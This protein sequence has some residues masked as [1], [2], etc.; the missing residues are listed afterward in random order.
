M[1]QSEYCLERNQLWNLSNPMGTGEYYNNLALLIAAKEREKLGDS[2]LWEHITPFTKCEKN[3]GIPV[4]LL[5]FT[6]GPQYGYK[7]PELRRPSG[8]VNFTTADKP[9]VWLD[10]KDT[11]A[12][13]G[14]QKRVTMRCISIGW[15]IYDIQ[16]QRGSMLF[17]N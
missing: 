8:T 6:V 12:A 3:P 14:G 2:K 13:S 17:G 4:S 16:E 10:I 15:G 1:F 9:T 7:A 5:S 11:L